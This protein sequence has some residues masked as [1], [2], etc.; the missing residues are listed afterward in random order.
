MCG[1]DILTEALSEITEAN[2]DSRDKNSSLSDS[3]QETYKR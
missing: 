2:T 1:W 3:L